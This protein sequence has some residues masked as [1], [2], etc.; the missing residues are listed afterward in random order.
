MKITKIP[1]FNEFDNFKPYNNQEI[2]DLNL[3]IVK[4]SDKNLFLNKNHNLS[5]GMFLKNLTNY[6]IVSFKEPSRIEKTNYVDYVNELL[7]TKISDDPDED[8]YIKKIVYNITI[9]LLEK[10]RNK[11]QKTLIFDTLEECELYQANNGGRINII[12]Q[13]EETT[14]YYKNTYVSDLDCGIDGDPVCSKNLED[15]DE[16]EHIGAKI[17]RVNTGKTYYALTVS[18]EAKLKNGFRYIKELLVQHHNYFMHESHQN[19]IKNK[20]DVYSVKLMH[21]QLN[22]QMLILL[23][24]C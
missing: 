9:G 18:D 19:L 10:S 2:K 17:D 7:N 11:K 16:I 12:K 15:S 1:I 20:I 5:Y 4:T 13:Y 14:T 22:H 23:S 24:N 6:E 21:F 8:M 3:Y